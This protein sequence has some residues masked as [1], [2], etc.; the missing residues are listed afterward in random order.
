M[1]AHVSFRID[2]KIAQRMRNMVHHNRGAPLFL[3]VDGYVEYL[4]ESGVAD[5]EKNQNNG[6]PYAPRKEK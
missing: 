3:T 1:K 5:M 4:I 2:A 6:K